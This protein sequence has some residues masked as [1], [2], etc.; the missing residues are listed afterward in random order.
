MTDSI[1]LVVMAIAGIGILWLALG[2]VMLLVSREVMRS[3][4]RTCTRRYGTGETLAAEVERA[5]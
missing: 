3:N 1:G 5:P 2:V 4:G